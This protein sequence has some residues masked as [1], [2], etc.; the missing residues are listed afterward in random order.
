MAFSAR[1]HAETRFLEA[2][3]RNN[4]QAPCRRTCR[5]SRRRYAAQLSFVVLA[6]TLRASART[7]KARRKKPAE[8]TEDKVYNSS[9]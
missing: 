8:H 2:A 3:G 1:S 9:I 5:S 6:D 4:G 7:T